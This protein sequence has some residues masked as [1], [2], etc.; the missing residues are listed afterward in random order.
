MRHW[1]LVSINKDYLDI[2]ENNLFK[3]VFAFLTRDTTATV[4]LH[5]KAAL[6]LPIHYL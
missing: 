2:L 6:Q 3:T 1:L 5:G 4:C